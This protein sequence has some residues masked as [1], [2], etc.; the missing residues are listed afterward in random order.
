MTNDN[1]NRT[2]ADL[3]SFVYCHKISSLAKIF[4]IEMTLHHMA[5]LEHLKS[6]NSQ[7]AIPNP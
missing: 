5:A 1:H 2:N 3:E 4:K 6:K 7:F